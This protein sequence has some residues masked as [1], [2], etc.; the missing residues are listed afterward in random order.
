MYQETFH[1]HW[2]LYC[3][4]IFQTFCSV[5]DF[6]HFVQNRSPWAYNWGIS[7]EEAHGSQLFFA[8][9]TMS[10]NYVHKSIYIR[11]VRIYRPEV[12]GYNIS[13]SS[14]FCNHGTTQLSW[15]SLLIIFYIFLIIHV[16]DFVWH[17]V[18]L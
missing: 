9:K 6:P 8:Q 16:F 10:T 12:T 1:N 4:S 5:L 17:V 3:I 11:D 7:P 13:T 18:C 2:I 14:N 15:G